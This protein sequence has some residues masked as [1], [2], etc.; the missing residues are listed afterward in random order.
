MEPFSNS[1]SVDSSSNMHSPLILL[2]FLFKLS[3]ID[4]KK[5]SFDTIEIKDFPNITKI[6][7]ISDDFSEGLTMAL[8]MQ[9]TLD[10][11]FVRKY[12]NTYPKLNKVSFRPITR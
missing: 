3:V 12:L 9:R 2:L 6:R 1:V 10:N 5:V 4:L 8:E 11:F 7:Y